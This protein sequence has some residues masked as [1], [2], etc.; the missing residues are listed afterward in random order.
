MNTSTTM[1]LDDLHKHRAVVAGEHLG[2]AM[3]AVS[4][5]VTRVAQALRAPREAVRRPAHTPR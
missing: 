5:W 2:E 3:L 1:A 4:R